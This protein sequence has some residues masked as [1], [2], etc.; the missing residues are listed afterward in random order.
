MSRKNPLYRER[1]LCSLVF[2]WILGGVKP[3]AAL[4]VS[5]HSY[6]KLVLAQSMEY[7]KIQAGKTAGLEPLFQAKAVLDWN[8]SSS[9]DFLQPVEAV[10]SIEPV[11]LFSSRLEKSF[12][13]GTHINLQYSYLAGEFSTAKKLTDE[14]KHP[15]HLGI[16]QDLMRNIFGYEDRTAMAKA[17]AQVELNHIKLME[18]TEDLIIQS[19]DRFWQAYISQLKL[20]LKRSTKKDYQDLMKITRSKKHYSYTRPGEWNQILAELEKAKQDLI[21]QKMDYEDQIKKLADLLNSPS[22]H[23]SITLTRPSSLPSAPPVLSTTTAK[24]SRAVQLLQ[25]KFFIQ[26][27]NLKTRKSQTWPALKLYAGYGFEGPSALKSF[28]PGIDKNYSYGLKFQYFIPS[29]GVRLKRTT[30]QEQAVEASRLDLEISKKDFHRL[31]NFTQKNLQA[32]Y[33][34]VNMSKKIYKLRGKSYKQIRRAYL[35]GRLN[36]FELIAAK[37]SSQSS[38]VEHIMLLSQYYNA[39]AV[40]YALR[41]ELLDQYLLKNN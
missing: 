35:Q 10:K 13:T 7:K 16:E 32:L 40:A 19:I 24:T 28:G 21:L 20:K 36:V 2:L 31:M 15:F 4:T 41:D 14:K 37:T 25:K 26:Q 22:R 30:I 38:E 29:S 8:L 27:E 39:L 1:W 33:Q 9:W 12:L 3:A 5:M 23:S 11:S 17:Q 6:V 34:A 18:E